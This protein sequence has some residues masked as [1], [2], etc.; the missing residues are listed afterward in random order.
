MTWRRSR[1]PLLA[2][3]L[4]A[5]GLLALS[6]CGD[7]GE[8]RADAAGG[9]VLSV[10]NPPTQA[11]TTPARDRR[12]AS[13][14]AGRLTVHVTRPVRLRA[15]PGG[16]VVGGVLPKTEFRSD[17]ILPV[18]RQQDGWL[19]V[20]SKQLPNARIGWIAPNA[21]LVSYRT[22]WSIAVSLGRREVVVRHSGNVVQRFRVAVGGPST[23]T[24]TGR[25][26]VTDKLLTH[27]PASVYGC[28]ILALSAHQP[29]TPQGWGGGD[30][31]GIHATNLP[32]TIGTAASLGCLRAPAE[33]ARRLVRAIPLG[34]VVRIRA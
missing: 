27:D 22:R 18:V 15:T 23:P 17:T 24:P 34:T 32:E 13:P 25:F 5:L 14:S 19:G 8:P 30:R 12:A 21:H 28:C 29:N 4:L 10:P 1:L 33:E 20:I 16:A 31:V 6:G 3:P 2:L 26:A 7:V 11:R 9:R